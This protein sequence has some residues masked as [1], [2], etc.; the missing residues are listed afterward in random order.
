MGETP[1]APEKYVSGGGASCRFGGDQDTVFAELEGAIP[2]GRLAEY[3]RRGANMSASSAKQAIGH[4]GC[5][6]NFS[7][8]IQ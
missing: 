8:A 7:V 2:P 1:P 6:G 3:R 4:S 5:P